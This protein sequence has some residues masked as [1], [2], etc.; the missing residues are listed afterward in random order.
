MNQSIQTQDQAQVLGGFL[1]PH[2][3][4]LEAFLRDHPSRRRS[5]PGEVRLG[6]R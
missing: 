5:L 2:H 4:K 6:K 1:P 3:L